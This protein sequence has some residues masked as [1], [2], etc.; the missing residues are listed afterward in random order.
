MQDMNRDRVYPRACGGTMPDT[1][2][3]PMRGGLSPRLRG[4]RETPGNHRN[5]TRSIPA[6]AGEPSVLLGL[7]VI[8]TVYPRACGGTQPSQSTGTPST[9]LSPRLRGNLVN[10]GLDDA[11][12]RSIPAP[13]G[14]PRGRRRHF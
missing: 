7:G 4:N 2:P 14:E 1:R 12:I 5:H 13:A 10:Q 3:A 9:G 8:P 6:P 11:L